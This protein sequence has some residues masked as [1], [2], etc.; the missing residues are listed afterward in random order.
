MPYYESMFGGGN[1]S[2]SEVKT[3][4]HWIDGK[5]IYR[6]V[7]DLGA[8]PDASTKAVNHG[9]TNA[10]Q[11]ISATGIINQGGGQYTFLPCPNPTIEYTM[12]MWVDGTK[13]SIKTGDNRTSSTAYAFLEY[14]KT[15]D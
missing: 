6:K 7:I 1:Y 11:F 3:G 10:A 13:V 8:L 5:P 9:I 12:A 15:T 2:T 14:T 4:K